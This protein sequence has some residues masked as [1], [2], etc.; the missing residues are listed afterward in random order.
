MPTTT[1]LLQF[2]VASLVLALTPGPSIVLLLAVGADRGRRAG[3]ATALGLAVGTSTW[4]VVAAAGLGSLL[5]ARPGLL[6][7]VTAL[8]GAYL[9]WLAWDRVRVT[10]SSSVEVTR[11][12]VAV[13]PDVHRGALRDG[14]VVNLL[15]PS[16][17]I[18]LASI[19]PPFLEVGAAAPPV[20]VQVLVLS[21]VLVAVSTVV[22]VG[23][24]LLGAV[25]GRQARHWVGGRRTVLATAVVY[26][27]LGALAL[28]VALTR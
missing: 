13:A 5:A 14:I 3:I 11:S 17:V 28:V 23:F 10:R 26:A 24:G 25:V 22:N 2:A 1:A 7:V 20:G 18:F 12:A 19:V 21:G 9:L 16:I 27:G 4:G 15:N 8:G 6:A